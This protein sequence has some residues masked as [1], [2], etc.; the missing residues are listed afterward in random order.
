MSKRLTL[1]ICLLIFSF[2]LLVHSQ[3]DATTNRLG[4]SEIPSDDQSI[5]A[6]LNVLGNLA[7]ERHS[8]HH[9]RNE[10]WILAVHEGNDVRKFTDGK[11]TL[12]SLPVLEL[13]ER[14]ATYAY[15]NAYNR[16]NLQD[17]DSLVLSG[18][19]Q[20]ARQIFRLVE[21]FGGS[22][23]SITTLARSGLS[24]LTRIESGREPE[25]ARA[26]LMGRVS[27]VQSRHDYSVAESLQPHMVKNLLEHSN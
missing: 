10:T 16:Y 19:Y 20:E 12:L 18:N 1:V 25:S 11:Y 14:A 17:A 21:R 27:E 5:T 4:S 23:A 26:E 13:P 7:A 3:H 6:L 15:V 2:A 8:A 22:N 9:K 24:L